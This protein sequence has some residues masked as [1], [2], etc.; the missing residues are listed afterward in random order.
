MA[1]GRL[2]VG[3]LRAGGRLAVGSLWAGGRL[4]VAS[5]PGGVQQPGERRTGRRGDRLDSFGDR[6]V[7]CGR[8]RDHAHDLA[9]DDDRYDDEVAAI[10]TER[11][12]QQLVDLA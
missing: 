8:D 1:G 10:V 11:L 5:A 3:S 2:A 9:G 4:A 6:R 12:E 7:R